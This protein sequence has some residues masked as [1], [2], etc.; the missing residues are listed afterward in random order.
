MAIDAVQLVKD[1]FDPILGLDPG[2]EAAIPRQIEAQIALQG[3][4]AAGISDQRAVYISVLATQ[5]LIP[6][7]LNK[8]AQEIKRAKGADSEAEFMDA[9]EFLKALQKQLEQQVNRAA[10]EAAP[11]DEQGERILSPP[12]VGVRGI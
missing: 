9:I 2:L 11:E 6:R 5:A 10:R 12:L 1:Q 3:W 8:F 7:L 4:T